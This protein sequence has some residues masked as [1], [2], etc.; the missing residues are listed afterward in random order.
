MAP[1]RSLDVELVLL[2]TPA[3]RLTSSDNLRHAAFAAP[4][5]AQPSPHAIFRLWLSVAQALPD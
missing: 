4:L 1:T 3:A 5:T 2:A